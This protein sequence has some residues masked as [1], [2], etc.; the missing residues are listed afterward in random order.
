MKK[1]SGF[2]GLNKFG[3]DCCLTL[4]DFTGLDD[5]LNK[6][7]AF[8][9]EENYTDFDYLS[10]EFLNHSYNLSLMRDDVKTK[11]NNE[12][13]PLSFA[14]KHNL[15]VDLEQS[16]SATDNLQ[17]FFEHASKPLEVYMALKGILNEEYRLKQ[18]MVDV[19]EDITNQIQMGNANK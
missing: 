2:N 13:Y 8:Y 6:L 4:S 10:R 15:Q 7:R 17:D 19:L 16:L 18:V 1:I 12:K 3:Q 9:H 14:V 11:E 5:V